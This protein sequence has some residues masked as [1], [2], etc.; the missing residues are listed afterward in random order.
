MSPST[1]TTKQP[2]VTHGATPILEGARYLLTLVDEEDRE[3]AFA[4]SLVRLMGIF[5]QQP[6]GISG[7]TTLDLVSLLLAEVAEDD[8]EREC[9]SE[10]FAAIRLVRPQSGL[11]DSCQAANGDIH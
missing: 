7:N 11:V 9:C 5:L 10:I 6:E 1:T 3:A 4:A 2:L 8:P